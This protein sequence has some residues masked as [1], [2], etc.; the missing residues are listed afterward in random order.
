MVLYVFFLHA[1]IVRHL[2]RALVLLCAKDHLTQTLPLERI[3][4]L[5][6][7]LRL[8]EAGLRYGVVGDADTRRLL[9]AQASRLLVILVL[10]RI[11]GRVR[12]LR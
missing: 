11:A 10:V 1:I 4:R 12:L 2:R 3:L 7:L 9:T 6:G 5:G 8:N